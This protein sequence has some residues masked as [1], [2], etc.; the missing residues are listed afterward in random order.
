MW[1][2]WNIDPAVNLYPL[3][4]QC[5]YFL[6]MRVSDKNYSYVLLE[7]RRPG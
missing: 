5:N 4:Y 2:D 6:F 7:S 3:R 1:K